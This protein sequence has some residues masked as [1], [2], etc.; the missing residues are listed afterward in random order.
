VLRN[1]LYRL[2]GTP[3][4]KDFLD[5]LHDVFP[6]FQ[7]QVA[8]DD[9]IDEWIEVGFRVGAG[10]WIPLELAGTGV[11]QAIQILSY[12][13]RFA[14]PIVVLDEPDSH[15]H[16][17]NQRLMCGLLRRL[18]DEGVTQV[19]LT[20]HSRHVVDAVGSPSRFL[21]VRN[22]HVDVAGP[23]D[24]IGVLLDIGALDIKE[25]AA[26]PGTRAVVFTEDENTVPLGLVLQASGFVDADVAVLPY[27]GVTGLKQ[28]RPLVNV[29]KSSNPKAKIIVHRDR[30]LMTPDEVEDWKTG[31][32]ALGA[33][34]F[35][36]KGV[37]VESYFIDV[38]HLAALNPDSTEEG[39]SNLIDRVLESMKP[40]LVAAYVNG[41][42]ELERKAGTFGS[43]NPGKLAV[44]ANANVLS[45]PRRYA[46]KK[47]LKAIR[48]VFRDEHTMNL[49]TDRVT[50]HLLDEDLALIAKKLPRV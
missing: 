20:T 24:E 15:L 45:N 49:R 12:I 39:L 47:A 28:L 41:R 25:R 7:L 11:L 1:I 26:Q 8:F 33:E 6:Q 16:P 17:N 27:Y 10:E 5:D 48:S 44:D 4:W 34:P 14:P 40:D 19:L 22:G 32:R 18:T 50:N 21:W 29:I 46:G 23:D 3:V 42:T 9:K 38:R 36:T 31:V 30:D 43:V 37:D 35:V 2:W 13:H